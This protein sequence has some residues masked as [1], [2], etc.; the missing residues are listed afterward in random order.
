MEL[1][2]IRGVIQLYCRALAGTPIEVSDTTTL[3]QKN[4]GWVHEDTASTDG[5]TI[6]LP[7]LVER[8]PNQHD[9]FAWFK[10]VATHQVAHLE[11]GSFAF[12]FETPSTMFTDRRVQ[13][14]REIL[15]HVDGQETHAGPRPT[16]TMSGTS[17]P[18]H[19]SPGGAWSKRKSWK[20]ASPPA[21][22]RP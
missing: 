21:I 6:F 15:E 22:T 2:H 19:I 12:T 16:P 4:I 20:R 8:Y 11:F 14:E 17:A 1:A 10:V 5:T 13:C 9:N 18:L 3:V 7:P